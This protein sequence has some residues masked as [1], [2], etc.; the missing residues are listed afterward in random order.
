[1][2]DKKALQ[3]LEDEHYER[4]KQYKKAEEEL[5]E[6]FHQFKSRTDDLMEQ[7]Y[8]AYRHLPAQEGRPFLAELQHNLMA[9]QRDYENRRSRIDEARQ[10]DKREFNKKIEALENRAKETKDID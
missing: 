6:Y 8:Y 2:I 9:Y 5:E 4:L 1:M 3:A 10:K 7:I